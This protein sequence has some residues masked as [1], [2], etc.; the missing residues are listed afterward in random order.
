MR[1]VIIE[2]DITGATDTHCG[3]KVDGR[4]VFCHQMACPFGVPQLIDDEFSKRSD[5]CI[6]L[7]QKNEKASSIT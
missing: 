6:E 3:E 1:T 5:R 7:E 4:W 2:V